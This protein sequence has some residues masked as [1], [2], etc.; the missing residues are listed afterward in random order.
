[1]GEKIFNKLKKEKG[2]K[3]IPQK[4]SRRGLGQG[5]CVHFSAQRNRGLTHIPGVH[6]ISPNGHSEMAE[7]MYEEITEIIIIKRIYY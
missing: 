4:L 7:N 6:S 2:A 5:K 3:Y 1:M